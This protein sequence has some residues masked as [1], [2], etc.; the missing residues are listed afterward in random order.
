MSILEI[1]I[2]VFWVLVGIGYGLRCSGTKGYPWP[3]AIAAG[4]MWP[5]RL[6]G[7]LA[8]QVENYF[9]RQKRLREQRLYPEHEYEAAPPSGTTWE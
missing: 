3:F 2:A 1:I 8:D 9:D 5:L 4:I 7:M 6:G